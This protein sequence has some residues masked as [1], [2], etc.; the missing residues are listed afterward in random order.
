[1]KSSTSCTSLVDNNMS[2]V[3]ENEEDEENSIVTAYKPDK[4]RL[5]L[6]I[7][8]TPLTGGI[9]LLFIYWRSDWRL[10]VTHSPCE[11]KEAT[12]VLIKDQYKQL[13][14]EDVISTSYERRS[15]QTEEIYRNVSLRYFVHKEVRYI[16][17]NATFS[18]LVGLEKGKECAH[19]HKISH[20]MPRSEQTSQRVLY[21]TNCIV[22]QVRSYL[23]LFF[24][25]ALN[26]FYIFQV[27]S[28]TVWMVQLYFLYCGCIMVLSTISIALSV[29][30]TRRSSVELKKKVVSGS[31]VTVQRGAFTEVIDSD[32]LVPGDVIIIPDHHTKLECDAV[33]VNGNCVVNESM[34]TGES[35]P[36]TKTS[37]PN[38][39][40]EMY[41]PLT[42]KR[43]TL[44]C[45]TEVIQARSMNQESVKAVVV[46]TGFATA[47]GELVRSI[48]FP[49]PL[50][51]KLHR[52][53]LKF[54]GV[55]LIIAF[56]GLGFVVFTYLYH[57]IYEDMAITLLN[58]TTFCVPPAL[59]AAITIG[60]VLA[61]KRLEKA[62]IFCMSSRFINFTGALN[63]VCFDK[64]G[65][66]TNDG[67]DL[68]GLR[69]AENGRFLKE[70][71][72]SENL[73]TGSCLTCMATCHS[74]HI[75]DGKPDGYP[76]DVKM[77]E[78]TG[79]ILKDPSTLMPYETKFEKT[80]MAIVQSDKG[81][82]VAV[83]R[84]YTFAS[85]LQRMSVITK[86]E[87]SSEL[88]VYVKGS[89]EKITSISKPETVPEDWQDILEVYTR[90]GYRVIAL[91][92]KKLDP[93]IT[94]D[95]TQNLS[96]NKV[97]CDLE[98]LGLLIMEN[99]LKPETI[100]AMKILHSANIRTV[101]VTGD[102]ILTA[103]KVARDCDMIKPREMVIRITA[104][105]F[106]KGNPLEYSLRTVPDEATLE[107]QYTREID[108]DHPSEEMRIDIEEKMYHL[109]IDGKSFG[110]IR[111]YKP[112]LIPNIVRRGTVFARMLPEQKTHL[113][114][115]LQDMEYYVGMCGD[116]ANDCGALKTAH[117]GISLSVAEASVASPFTSQETNIMCVQKLMREGRTALVT[118][119]GLFKHLLCSAIIELVMILFLYYIFNGL[120]DPQ[121]L[122]IDLGLLVIIT[123]F[124]GNV[125]AYP[126]LVKRPPPSKLMATV[127]LL[128]I[129]SFLIIQC[130]FLTF[131]WLLM[132]AEPWYLKWEWDDQRF[133]WDLK[134]YEN[135]MMFCMGCLCI[136][137]SAITFSQ[138]APYRKHMF[139]NFLF[140]LCL[141]AGF[142]LTS[143]IWLW[144]GGKYN[145]FTGLFDHIDFPSYGFCLLLYASFFINVFVSLSCETFLIQD[146]L[147]Q[148][149]RPKM[150]RP[151]LK[152][153]RL[154]LELRHNETWP[155]LDTTLIEG[156]RFS[157]KGNGA[158]IQGT[159]AQSCDTHL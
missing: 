146:L 92:T 80:P 20:G 54:I 55:A 150:S 105:A 36:I 28:V 58:I 98:F 124:Y 19:F 56:V 30:E 4:V 17:E 69:R 59:P 153:Q 121:F 126:V 44:F 138:G 9:L 154:E 73:P 35:I 1:M 147:Y 95:D 142:I 57:E 74:L 65:T 137:N 87:D 149:L 129:G 42:H 122:Y 51:L 70:S 120:N 67:L 104:K 24:N 85:G 114:T 8:L 109:A 14:V 140:V 16:W 93:S 12:K 49:Q 96:R 84:Q 37:V 130:C 139:T 18:R 97:E 106:H 131:C 101:M 45:G 75:I 108:P 29:Y 78:A 135:T 21:G 61:Q 112:E 155:P 26:P 66:L 88:E 158:L 81:G 64:T 6:T 46:R 40:T 43:H 5:L 157:E 76:L 156:E 47:K 117:A 123:L 89:P 53:G 118:S 23:D 110:L 116:G 90:D 11:L 144:H 86:S 31:K 151:K 68:H 159:G 134:G 119:F 152:H 127:P 136:I 115:D 71:L 99:K 111:R 22:I 62:K 141:L 13:F 25:E 50:D 82:E 113:I 32:D 10:K 38:V 27:Y 41:T 83:I 132:Q 39:N 63:V 7:L 125:G 128:S 107:I 133:V 33:L 102:N 143:I 79:W 60:N 52:D 2:T 34:L 3:I 91:A 15:S 72:G 77:F 145:L 100:P 103:L 94:W 48:L 148:K